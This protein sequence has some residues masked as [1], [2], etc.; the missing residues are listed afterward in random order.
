MPDV[1]SA[2]KL[3][4]GPLPFLLIL[5]LAL[6]LRVWGIAWGLPDSAHR[7][8]YHPDES[9][10]LPICVSVLNPLAGQF[11]PHFYNYGSLQLCLVSFAVHALP[12]DVNQ[13]ARDLLIGR[14]LTA[15]M[16]VGTVAATGALG[17]SLW[18]RRCGLAS[19]LLL[20]LTP[21]HAQHSQFLTVDVPATFWTV[22]SLYWS[23]RLLQARPS[24]P[25]AE[26]EKPIG[27]GYRDAVLAG[28]FAGLAAAT[29][30]NLVL[31][32]APL[33][34]AALISKKPGV[35]LAGLPVMGL[36]F[37]IGCP[38][39]VLDRSQFMRDLTFEA[40]HVQNRNDSTFRDT[41][42]GF[43]YHI[44]HT[45]YA[46][47]GVSLLA[48]SL[49]AVAYAI[50]RRQK[51]DLLLAAFSLPYYIV[52]GLAA[53]RYARY[54]IPLLPF[55]ALWVARMFAELTRVRSSRVPALALCVG[56]VVACMTLL[57][58]VGLIRF[59][60]ESDSRNSAL[61]YLDRPENAAGT[62]GF[63]VMPWFQAVP[64]D[65]FFAAPLRGAWEEP[66]YEAPVD[67]KVLARIRY[68]GSDWDVSSLVKERPEFVVLCEYDYDD[69]LRLHD[70]AALRY[71]S[72]LQSQYVRAEVYSGTHG[73]SS[74]LPSRDLPHD[75]L[76]PSP[77]IVVFR[78]RT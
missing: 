9:R 29:K 39:T 10:I 41:G 56:I 63:G 26:T 65:P 48:L 7:F 36:A 33:I 62:V 16:G 49:I 69:P 27:S 30:Y 59:M 52:I 60:V 78:R 75:M 73:T 4:E 40:V 44:T 20:A 54:V 57:T 17:T 74:E 66:M 55:L 25:T 35:L 51:G 58:A 1:G 37:L 68:S 64:L 3:L 11:L 71:L 61:A 15:L 18:G 19:A 28:L 22:V 38:G 6:F 34:A 13:T 32:A 72:A 46:G 77:A 14:F 2:S 12:G 67:P 43:V 53:V 5:M 24:A 70:P 47:Q 45:L 8:S 23:A 31:A 50:S 42:N 21:L 76:Y